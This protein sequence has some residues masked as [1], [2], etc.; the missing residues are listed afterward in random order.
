[1]FARKSSSH[2]L[3]FRKPISRSVTAPRIIIATIKEE[4]DEPS[5]SASAPV[6]TRPAPVE[7]EVEEAA[8]G[9]KWFRA[10]PRRQKLIVAILC[11]VR[12][13]FSVFVLLIPLI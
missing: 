10:M 2:N 8:G 1:M 4:D 6:L 9:L 7:D 12:K 13:D 5:V 11:L 3:L